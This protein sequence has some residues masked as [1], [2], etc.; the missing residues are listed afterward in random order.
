MKVVSSQ[1]KKFWIG[2]PKYGPPF[3]QIHARADGPDRIGST[4]RS[5]AVMT[6]A[7]TA[8]SRTSHDDP[9]PRPRRVAV[10]H[11]VRDHVARVDHHEP[12]Q[13]DQVRDVPEL[14]AEV[15][16]VVVGAEDQAGR[17]AGLLVRPGDD[18]AQ[19]EEDERQPPTD[20]I[21]GV[22]Q[23]EERQ[24]RSQE[25]QLVRELG[26]PN[27][28]DQRAGG[29]PRRRRR[30]PAARRRRSAGSGRASLLRARSR[31]PT[32]SARYRD[33]CRTGGLR[34]GVR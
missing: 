25:G 1:P 20:R 19:A 22:R 29:R 10:Q 14:R 21:P 34:S 30:P 26:Q 5:H 3:S 31:R 27:Q 15:V 12:G 24:D 8:A 7:L 33:A 23:A 28:A 11:Q 9:R 17:H 18:R 16:R 2:M 13:R 6:T 4:T 32:R